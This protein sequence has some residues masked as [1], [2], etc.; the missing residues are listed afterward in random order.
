MISFAKQ[1]SLYNS[2]TSK[3]TKDYLDVASGAG[4]ALGV[5]DSA[6]GYWDAAGVATFLGASQ[7]GGSTTTD[8]FKSGSLIGFDTTNATA[9]TFTYGA[10]GNIGTSTLNGVV[11]LGTGTLGS[12]CRQHLHRRDEC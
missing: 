9:G 12:R 10:I 5:G 4:L 8:G 1:A 6:S 11:K 2:T 3:W 7:M